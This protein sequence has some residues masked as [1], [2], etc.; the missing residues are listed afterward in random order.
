M[1]SEAEQPIGDDLTCLWDIKKQRIKTMDST[2]VP[3]SLFSIVKLSSLKIKNPRG[4]N[5]ETKKE[6]TVANGNKPLNS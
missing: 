5:K 1:I 3:D 2:Q 4:K 6:K